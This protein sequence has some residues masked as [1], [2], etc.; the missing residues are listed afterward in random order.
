MPERARGRG[1]GAPR[2]LV[3]IR[4][5]LRRAGLVPNT[6][7]SMTGLDRMRHLS[8]LGLLTLACSCGPAAEQLTFSSGM[9]L[10]RSAVFR[11][12][13]VRI[14]GADSLDRPVLTISGEGGTVDFN[15]DLRYTL[16]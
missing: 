9:Q 12:D 2:P 5:W 15:G 7:A 8:T 11:A 3:S 14:P 1:R 10:Q 13:T 16:V 6:L 4:R